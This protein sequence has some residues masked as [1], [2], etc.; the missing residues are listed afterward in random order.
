M[1][2]PPGELRRFAAAS[3]TNSKRITT[4]GSTE[5]VGETRRG[6]ATY[7]VGLTVVCQLWSDGVP[8]KTAAMAAESVI[9]TDSRTASLV[10]RP[11][12]TGKKK[13]H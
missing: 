11:I 1:R 5:V 7:V 3:V 2:T 10:S 4:S 6:K 12:G 8:S 9:R 13:R